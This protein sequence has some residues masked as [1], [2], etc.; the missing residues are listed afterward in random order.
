MKWFKK[1]DKTSK[2][3]MS[4][5]KKVLISIGVIIAL[6][7]GLRMF[8]GKSLPENAIGLEDTTI[9][10][11]SDF[12]A[13]VEG[14]GVVIA[15]QDA[16]VYSSQSLP[17]KSV[18][19]KE[20]DIVQEGQV[21]AYL[22]DKTIRK[23]IKLK[24]AGLS[25]QA[26]NLAH[27]V[28]MAKDKYQTALNALNE[29][30]NSVLV[31]AEASLN[32][33]KAQWDAA[34]KIYRDYKNA[35]EE[36]YHPESTAQD[37]TLENARQAV[38]KAQKA[39]AQA[40][41]RYNDSQAH[42]SNIAGDKKTFEKDKSA[43]RFQRNQLQNEMTRLEQ[44][45]KNENSKNAFIAETLAK[46]EKEVN[47]AKLA[48]DTAS[49]A[50][51]PL[52]ESIYN[53]KK[54]NYDTYK[55]SNPMSST[56]SELYHRTQNELAEVN[57]L[58]GDAESDYARAKGE[59][60]SYDKNKIARKQ[61]LEN[62]EFALKQAENNLKIVEGQGSGSVKTREDILK[63][64]RQS[65]DT[66][67]QSYLTAKRN[68]EVARTQ[69]GS[70]LKG[71]SD[72]LKTSQITASDRTGIV[73]LANLYQDLEDTII[74]SPMSGTITQVLAKSGNSA[75]GVLFKVE[76]LDNLFVE[77][78]LKSRD[79]LKVKPGMKVRVKEN[80]TS[81][82]YYNGVV[83]SVAQSAIND[84]VSLSADNKAP[85]NSSG[86][87]DPNFK[88]RVR[89]DAPRGSLLVGMKPKVEVILKEEKAALSVPLSAIVY[90]TDKKLVFVMEEQEKDTYKLRAVEVATG[91]ENETMVAISSKDLKEGMMI[92]TNPTIQKD[93]ELVK[94]V[95]SLGEMNE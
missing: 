8:G 69:A 28:S 14:N 51:R 80:A 39:Y 70:E 72:G 55:A 11:M 6:V 25:T 57:R 60:E 43:Y 88:V 22:E 19:V 36:G 68:L 76:S 61:E 67:K 33:A 94:V 20:N 82:D 24:E 78:K 75:T 34:E 65:A 17:I 5:K 73:E 93:G 86:S 58:L 91:S 50:E 64:H 18:L 44:E 21:L 89:L 26:R 92:Y 53:N 63:T 16:G 66:A 41:E 3:K 62:A 54:A 52:K 42:N 7:I 81:D 46:L 13:S 31:S 77:A 47:E 74:R 85:S 27:Q 23:Q 48:L 49:E 9:L 12:S 84:E 87:K 4:K 15:E 29:G 10:A 83:V 30:N 95:E 79:I 59:E 37:A 35:L 45:L 2:R 56:I 32:T 1:S 40:K 38:E 90:E 71:L